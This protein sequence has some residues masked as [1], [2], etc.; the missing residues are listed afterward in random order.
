MRARVRH[1]TSPLGARSASRLANGVGDSH[2]G[3]RVLRRTAGTSR[4]PV[5]YQRWTANVPNQPNGRGPR[6]E[7]WPPEVAS[8]RW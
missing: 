8:S 2:A 5:L 7:W 3:G 4:W 1:C 6:R